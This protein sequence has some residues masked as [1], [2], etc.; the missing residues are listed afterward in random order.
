MIVNYRVTVYF[1]TVFGYILSYNIR[2]PLYVVREEFE[3]LKC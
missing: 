2:L 3:Y 1:R